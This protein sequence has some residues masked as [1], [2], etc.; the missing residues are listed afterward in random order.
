MN[1]LPAF[2]LAAAL[3]ALVYFAALAMLAAVLV[4]FACGLWLA[5]RALFRVGL[6]VVRTLGLVW[7]YDRAARRLRPA[8]A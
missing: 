2:V 3:A 6:F 4:A 1:S 5:L 8:V 7:A